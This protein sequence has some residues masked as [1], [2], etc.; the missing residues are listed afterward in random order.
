MSRH[1]G[2]KALEVECNAIQPEI[3]PGTADAEDTTFPPINE[4]PY[5]PDAP[6]YNSRI[7]ASFVRFIERYYGDIDVSELLSYANMAP[8]QVKDEDHWFNQEQVDLFHE[9]L[10]VLTKNQN[11]A[12]EAGRDAVSTDSLGSRKIR[13]GLLNPAVCEMGRPAIW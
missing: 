10:V 5:P 13:T 9:K 12:R 1:A 3:Q 4:L 7:I 8:Y 2:D 6:L 11:I